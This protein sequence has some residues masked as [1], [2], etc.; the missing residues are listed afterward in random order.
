MTVVEAKRN[1]IDAGIGQCVAQMVGV[2]RF[3]KA[4][5]AEID[6]IFGCVTNGENWLFLRLSKTT[7]TI[8]WDRFYIDRPD[9]ILGCL[10]GCLDPVLG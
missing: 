7:L 9:L 4:N 2:Q 5:S 10:R 6:P 1:D 3:N 8:D